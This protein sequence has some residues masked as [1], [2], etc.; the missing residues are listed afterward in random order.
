MLGEGVPLSEE[1]FKKTQLTGKELD[2]MDKMSN[3]L[4][5]SLKE[6][7]ETIGKALTSLGERLDKVESIL[8]EEC[9]L[10]I[11]PKASDQEDLHHEHF[12]MERAITTEPENRGEN[13]I[14]VNKT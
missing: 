3:F 7:F 9:N 4:L 13:E 6:E 12:G 5:R 10:V 8:L 11:T 2:I 1:D 14:V